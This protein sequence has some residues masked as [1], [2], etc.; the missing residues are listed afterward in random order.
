MLSVLIFFGILLM[1]CYLA[2]RWIARI[3]RRRRYEDVPL[4]SG[5]ALVETLRRAE[6]RKP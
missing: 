2:E 3:Q 4:V 6:E 1:L 5:F